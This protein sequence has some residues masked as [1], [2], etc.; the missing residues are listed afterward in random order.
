MQAKL[1]SK[2]ISKPSSGASNTSGQYHPENN[3]NV[4][5]IENYKNEQ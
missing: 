1:K 5:Q 3:R 2:N 4:C